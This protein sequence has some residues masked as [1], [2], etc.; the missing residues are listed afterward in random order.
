MSTVISKEV[1]AG[2][3][4]VAIIMSML[5]YVAGLYGLIY[6]AIILAISK[7]ALLLYVRNSKASKAGA[8]VLFPEILTKLL[9]PKSTKQAI[10]ELQRKEDNEFHHSRSVGDE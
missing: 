10:S 6:I 5:S 7:L 9:M 2:I 8:V 1:I 3:A 4:I